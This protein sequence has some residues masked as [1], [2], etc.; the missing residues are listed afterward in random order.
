MNL[1]TIFAVLEQGLVLWNSKEATKYQDQVLK[2]K[3]R[4]YEEYSK[5]LN[6]RSDVALDSIMLHLT[7]LCDSF[8]TASQSKNSQN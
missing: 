8:I 1:G 6:I 7:H 3:E 4:Y 5:P 2:L